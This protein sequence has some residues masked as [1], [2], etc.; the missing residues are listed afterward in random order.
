MARLRGRPVC[1]TRESSP[2]EEPVEFMFLC[3]S[4]PTMAPIYRDPCSSWKRYF[5]RNTGRVP[6]V[7]VRYPKKWMTLRVNLVK[8]IKEKFLDSLQNAF[9]SKVLIYHSIDVKSK[10]R[11]N[12]FEAMFQGKGD[13][14]EAQATCTVISLIISVNDF[15]HQIPF[16]SLDLSNC[17]SNISRAVSPEQT[18]ESVGFCSRGRLPV[19]SGWAI[20]S[21]IL[22]L[23]GPFS[24][25]GPI[26]FLDLF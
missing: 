12:I 26:W 6:S 3:P 17:C 7:S 19:P 22:I 2:E 20:V 10:R 16:S 15:P 24:I 21:I 14:A 1:R 18:N 23:G 11:R 25:H 4:T 5:N 13:C 9:C 8:S